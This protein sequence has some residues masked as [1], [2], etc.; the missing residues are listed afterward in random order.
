MRLSLAL[1]GLLAAHAGAAS[2]YEAMADEIAVLF[3]DAVGR[4]K[5]GDVQGA[6]SKI[7]SAYFDVFENLEG[8][9]RVNVSAQ[10]NY[11]LEEEFAEIR[12]MVLRKEPRSAIEGRVG[13]LKSRIREVVSE[14]EG[15]VELV[16]EPSQA[17]TEPGGAQPAWTQAVDAVEA[18][19]RAALD[20]HVKGDAEAAASL[21]ERAE[22]DHYR[23]SLL[24]VAIRGQLSQR[25]NFEH[26]ERFSD[27]A[28]RLR[29]RE[30][31]A[32][33]EAEAAGLVAELRK[34]LPG[35]TLVPGAKVQAPP[36]ERDWT[37]A[38]EELRRALG[39]AREL[40]LQGDAPGGAQA[41]RDA[42]FDVFE[43]LGLEAAVGARDPG[44]KAGLEADFSLL[45]ARIKAGASPPELEDAWA[46]IRRDLDGAVAPLKGK[47]SPWAVFF[48]SL[49]IILREGIEAL[50]IVATIVSY[51][52]KTGHRDKLRVIYHGCASAIAA[53][54][55]TAIAIKWAFKASA[56]SQ[57][58]LEGA[59]MLLASAVLF[60]VSYW[61][62]SKL[63]AR[64]WQRF[65]HDKVGSSLSSNS[66]RALWFAAF[67]AV[68]REG[69]ETVLFYQA[70]ASGSTAAGMGAELGGFVAGC[71]ILA[72]LFAAMRRGAVVIPLKP[73][74]LATGTL[75][76]LM[77]IAFSG[78]GMMELISAK[79]FEPALIAWAP[80]VPFLG[81]YPYAQTLLPQL[82]LVLAAAVALAKAAGPSSCRGKEV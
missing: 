57:E 41:L 5:R 70:L 28:R 24:E 72:V 20:A 42:Y 36:A 27:V 82:A 7:E 12:K 43:G 32:E 56:A 65:I 14:L 75:L 25:R 67:L 73:F 38:A 46:K 30:G 21:V 78:K 80:T 71:L 61:L 40:H 53:S 77:A 37:K 81:V 68:Y 15:G 76:Y 55:A 19:L 17:A 31:R 9:I 33:I 23:G 13:A 39:A 18:G 4:Y 35:L 59:T 64:K 52:V 69:A 44:A 29:E 63:E 2:K 34:D 58:A 6:K 60:S 26:G 45:I 49:M 51:L 48:Y 10:A 62:I 22:L 47:D 54:I 16:A 50:L 11:E 79:L 3:D 1:A 66:L 74:F 8:P